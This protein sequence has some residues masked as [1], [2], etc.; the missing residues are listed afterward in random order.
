MRLQ[1]VRI[2][3]ENGVASKSLQVDEPVARIR[4]VKERE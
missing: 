4:N 3:K 1:A 2:S